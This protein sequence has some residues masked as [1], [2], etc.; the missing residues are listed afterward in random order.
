M[1][2][3][4]AEDQE[5]ISSLNQ[6]DHDLLITIG[7]RLEGL[8]MTCNQLTMALGQKA[9]MTSIAQLHKE[10]TE[11]FVAAEKR[12][13]DVEKRIRDIERFNWKTAGVYAFVAV[14]A[15]FV[16]RYFKV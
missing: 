14:V 13:E 9:D 16:L 2:P 12:S 4:R 7:A 3:R 1:A 11:K 10:F 5:R 6:R 8:V 15:G